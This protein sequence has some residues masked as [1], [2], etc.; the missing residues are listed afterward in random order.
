MTNAEAIEM[1]KRLQ[2]P[3]PWEPQL[4]Y[5]AYDALKL[6]ISALEKQERKRGLKNGNQT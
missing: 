2:D 3:E 5:A 4:T 6:A 1:L